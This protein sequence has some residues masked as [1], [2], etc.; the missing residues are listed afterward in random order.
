MN[1]KKSH[2][3]IITTILIIVSIFIVSIIKSYSIDNDRIMFSIK[4]L[5]WSIVVWISVINIVMIIISIIMYDVKLIKYDI[6]YKAYNILRKYCKTLANSKVHYLILVIGIV[7][8]AIFIN[9]LIDIMSMVNIIDLPTHKMNIPNILITFLVIDFA[10]T[11][12][13]NYRNRNKLECIDWDLYLLSIRTFT[14][15]EYIFQNLKIN[16]DNIKQIKMNEYN[17]KNWNE[18]INLF[19]KMGYYKII[20]RNEFFRNTIIDLDKEIRQIMKTNISILDDDIYKVLHKIKCD[21][22][23]YNWEYNKFLISEIDYE[24][25]EIFIRRLINDLVKLKE[26][27]ENR[28]YKEIENIKVKLKNKDKFKLSRSLRI[29]RLE[30]GYSLEEMI[31][32]IEGEEKL[33]KLS[34]KELIELEVKYRIIEDGIL[35]CD[36]VMKSDIEKLFSRKDI[37]ECEN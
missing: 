18:E 36:K 12:I 1:N 28:Y 10:L 7:V 20:S 33:N 23:R 5:P 25:F 32:K 4:K 11:V 26:P 30:S 27:W 24:L 6:S 14:N 37:F 3:I 15:L 8:I 13:A 31:Y 35:K 17:F 21:I 16:S 34:K 29:L 2:R 9:K 22:S 19:N